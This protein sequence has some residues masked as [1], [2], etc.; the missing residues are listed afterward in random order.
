MLRHC[1][2]LEPSARPVLSDR[3]GP[4]PGAGD[5]PGLVGCFFWGGGLVPPS[6]WGF[7]SRRCSYFQMHPERGLA[8]PHPQ[9]TRVAVRN[10]GNGVAGGEAGSWS[11]D[12]RGKNSPANRQSFSALDFWITTSISF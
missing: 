10:L 8:A 7:S 2:W 9:A 1:R 3:A 12:P 6:T 4:A 11:Q 5:C